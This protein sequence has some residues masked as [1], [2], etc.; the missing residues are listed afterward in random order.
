MC[1]VIMLIHVLDFLQGDGYPTMSSLAAGE[2]LVMNC[3]DDPELFEGLAGIEG[4]AAVLVR[5]ET[6]INY[7]WEAGAIRPQCAIRG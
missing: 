1:L 7:G 6:Y 5:N 3:T 2:F 4:D